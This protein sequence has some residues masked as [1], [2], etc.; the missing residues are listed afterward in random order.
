MHINSSRH[1]ALR[2][3]KLRT[4]VK[5]L[6]IKK[7]EGGTGFQRE[8]E[9]RITRHLFFPAGQTPSRKRSELSQ[10]EQQ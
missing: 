4:E 8:D 9:K 6:F 10:A 5:E 7:K 1:W 2:M 3:R